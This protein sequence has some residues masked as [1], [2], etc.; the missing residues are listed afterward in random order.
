M[1]TTESDWY[2]PRAAPL[3]PDENAT[4]NPPEVRE[5]V[6]DRLGCALLDLDGITVYSE[7]DGIHLDDA[8]HA[9]VATAVEE[10]VRRLTV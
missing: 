5:K 8:G 3:N 4:A 9:A 7:L 2:E 1:G 6:C 10:R